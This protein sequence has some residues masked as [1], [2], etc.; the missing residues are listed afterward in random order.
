[1]MTDT[2][3]QTMATAPKDGELILVWTEGQSNYVQFAWWSDA[4]VDE[5]G[6]EYPD[7]WNLEMDGE[8]KLWMRIPPVSAEPR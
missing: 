3:W 8:P 5:Y 2:P 4:H 6:D 7:S 1:M